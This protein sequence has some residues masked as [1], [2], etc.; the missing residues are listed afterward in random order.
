[1]EPGG[2]NA[3]QIGPDFYFELL[4]SKTD[5]LDLVRLEVFFLIVLLLEALSR[6]LYTLGS[7]SLALSNVLAA[8]AFRNSLTKERNFF[9]RLILL[10]RFLTDCLRAFL[11]DFVI[12]IAIIITRIRLTYVLFFCKFNK[13]ALVTSV[14]W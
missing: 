13:K 12:G 6:A 5:N 8:M 11:A 3:N 2:K 4:F 7:N 10:A 14:W 1:M 9:F